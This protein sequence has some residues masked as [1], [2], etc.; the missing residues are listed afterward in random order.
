MAGTKGMTH[1]AVARQRKTYTKMSQL[2]TYPQYENV[3][4]RDFTATRANQ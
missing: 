2:A 4:N 1:Y 3:L